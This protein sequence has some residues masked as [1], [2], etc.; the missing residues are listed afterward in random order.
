MRWH[1]SCAQQPNVAG[2]QQ[3]AEIYRMFL[4]NCTHLCETVFLYSSK[5]ASS[6]TGPILCKQRCG[7]VLRWVL[8]S[9]RVSDLEARVLQRSSPNDL[10]LLQKGP[11]FL[12]DPGSL[13]SN[14]DPHPVI[15]EHRE[16]RHKIRF[17]F[18][19]M[20]FHSWQKG[21]G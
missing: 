15:G 21:P 2:S 19:Q 20:R 3:P 16:L 5:S 7:L 9:S 13:P 18:F 6:G 8:K 11:M 1:G 12:P 4:V 10:P 14:W 17:V